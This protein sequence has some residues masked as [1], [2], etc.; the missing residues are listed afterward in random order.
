MGPD[1][2]ILVAELAMPDRIQMEDTYA[3]WMDMTMFTFGG[4]ERSRTDWKKLFDS[5]GL[6]LVKV[7]KAPVGT[8]AVMEGKKKSI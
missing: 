8:Q 6:E 7:W 4:K 2:I 5:A 3:Y 1:S